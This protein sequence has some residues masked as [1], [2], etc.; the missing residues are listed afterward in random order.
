MNSEGFINLM[1]GLQRFAPTWSL[2]SRTYGGISGIFPSLLTIEDSRNRT[3]QALHHDEFKS[4]S[5]PASGSYAQPFLC[6]NRC[7]HPSG[8]IDVVHDAIY[9]S[10]ESCQRYRSSDLLRKYPERALHRWAKAYG[11][12]FS[13]WMGNQL[14]IV[15]SD[16]KV[17]RDLLVTQGAIF[18]SRKDYFMKNQ[19]ILAGRTI[20]AS[21]YGDTCPGVVYLATPETSKKNRE[22]GIR[23]DAG[24]GLMNGRGEAGKVIP[25]GGRLEYD[26]H[27]AA[28]SSLANRATGISSQPDLTVLNE[29]HYRRVDVLEREVMLATL[30]GVDA[31][32][33]QR[34]GAE[35]LRWGFRWAYRARR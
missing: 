5:N 11:P 12:L 25:A 26:D 6:K 23:M 20:T 28:G 15:I 33:L 31:N 7:I 34:F 32:W 16:P 17:A 24:H 30:A 2:S 29:E 1:P 18:S 8:H 9:R 19:T 21:A 22:G 13:V 27:V 10:K 3:T 4:Y 35:Q 14:F